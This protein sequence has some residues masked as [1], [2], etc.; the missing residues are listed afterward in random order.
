MR[1]GRGNW[2][3]DVSEVWAVADDPECLTLSLAQR[4]ALQFTS[5]VKKSGHVDHVELHDVAERLNRG[6][7]IPVA[8]SHGDF[9]GLL[10]SYWDNDSVIWMRWF[11]GHGRTLLF[12]TYNTSE[13]I[14]LADEN[15]ISNTLQTLCAR[16]N[17]TRN[18]LIQRAITGLNTFARGGNSS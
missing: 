13:H 11:L 17:D 12:V 10:Y 3:L 5:A 8:V 7:G 16:P 2:T 9:S 14:P 6:W 1:V 4:G 15:L 18:S